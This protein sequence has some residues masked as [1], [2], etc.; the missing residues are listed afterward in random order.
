MVQ[1]DKKV[2]SSGTLSVKINDKMRNY[3]KS[4]KGVQQGDPSIFLTL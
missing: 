1:L 2:V 4:R 3:F